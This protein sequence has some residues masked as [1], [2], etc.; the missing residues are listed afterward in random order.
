MGMKHTI[1]VVCKQ[2]VLH[3][4]TP[5]SS[6]CFCSLHAFVSTAQRNRWNPFEILKCQFQSTPGSHDLCTTCRVSSC[7]HFEL[8]I[9]SCCNLTS[10]GPFIKM[11]K[12][13]GSYKKILRICSESA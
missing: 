7:F 8:A 12:T 5:L 4:S 1:L 2:L 6:I 10:I 9:A 11:M 3:K 13:D